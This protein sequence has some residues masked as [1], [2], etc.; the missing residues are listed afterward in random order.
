M[1]RGASAGPAGPCVL[2]IFGITG[3]LARRLLFPALYNLASHKLLPEQFAIAGFALGDISEQQLQ[4]RLAEDLRQTIGSDADGEIIQWLISRLRFVGSDFE[5][6]SGWQ[7]LHTVLSEFDA[8]YKSGGNYL[9]YMAIAPEFFLE[10]AKRLA[11]EGFFT[12]QEG[13]WRRVIIEKPFGTDLDSAQR[14]NRELLTLVREEQIYRIDHYLGKE[15]VQNILV[16]R[17]A[18]GIFEPIW[19][20]R[21]IDHVQITVAESVG[22]ERRGR[23]FDVTGT[24]RDM[25]PNHLI[26]LLALTAMEPPSAFT[27]EALQN[28]QVK[29]LEAVQPID[30]AE[31]S[32]CV[33]RAQYTRGT[34][35]DQSVA[36]YREEAFVAQDSQTETYAAV[37]LAVDN[38]RWAS[39]PFFLRTGKRLRKRN[40]E[41]VIQFRNPPLALFRRSSASLPHPNRL[42]IA[43]QPQESISLEFE[44]KVPGPV[45]ETR[46]VDMQF[47]YRDYFGVENRTGYETLLYDAMI[48]DSSLFKRA[49]MIEAGWALIQPVLDAWRGEKGGELY[50]YPAGSDGPAAAD[51]L[52]GT[53]RH[54]RSLL[55]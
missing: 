41:I 45:I 54:W 38:W 16:F 33:V 31:C 9:F 42:V 15:T 17:F 47:E 36:G 52:I 46:G 39:V 32:E 37:K 23:Y 55:M 2:V 26:Q 27:A 40:T 6:E 3:D 7:Q 8:R 44:A 20:R 34:V 53:H 30:P 4:E 29:V 22:V 21:Y 14:L 28:E 10:V 35:G 25:V 18:N 13:R 5:S 48:G 51:T 50:H 1:T 19:N 12:E 11:H 49:D 43:I 24:L